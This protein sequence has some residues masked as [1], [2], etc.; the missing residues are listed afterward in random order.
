MSKLREALEIIS[1][2]GRW[3]KDSLAL[4]RDGHEEVDPENPE[5]YKFCAIGALRRVGVD[6]DEDYGYADR[7]LVPKEQRFLLEAAQ[8]QGFLNIP[9]FNDHRKTTKKKMVELFCT[10]ICMEEC[11]KERGANLAP[12]E[13]S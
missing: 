5:A 8:K 10:A 1:Q 9:A 13:R 6:A 3:I 7:N 12:Q 2:R 11:E 4:R